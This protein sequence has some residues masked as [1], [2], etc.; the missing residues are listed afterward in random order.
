M[1][2]LGTHKKNKNKKTQ[3]KLWLASNKD[4]HDRSD[5]REK[6]EDTCCRKLAWL[7]GGRILRLDIYFF[8]FFIF[9]FFSLLF[10]RQ[11]GTSDKPWGVR[12]GADILKN[13]FVE[14]PG[15]L[16]KVVNFCSFPADTGIRVGRLNPFF[17]L[18]FLFLFF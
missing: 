15:Q 10:T 8:Y 14:I 9:S 11:K 12:R 16:V 2:S 13:F 18:F 5:D 3:A 1:S 7:N 17:F 6:Q 4:G